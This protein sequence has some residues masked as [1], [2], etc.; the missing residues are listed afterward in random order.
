[1]ATTVLVWVLFHII[2][3]GVLAIDLGL[4]RRESRVV[5]PGEATLWTC[6]WVAISLLICGAIYLAAGPDLALQFLNGYVVEYSL[7]VDNLFVFLLLFQ[8]FGV[9][10]E[11]RHR[12]LFWG[13]AVQFAMRAPL[14]VVGTALASRF[15]WMLYLFG[16]F[17]LYTAWKMAFSGET[18]GFDPDKS[19]VLAWIGRF[20]PLAKNPPPG[21]FFAREGNKLRATQL[22]VVLLFFN[23]TDLMFALDSIPAVI[24]VVNSGNTFIVYSSNVCAIL[25]LRSLFF[26]IASL[27]DK[28]RYL[29]FGVSIILAFVGTKMIISHWIQISNTTSFAIIACVVAVCIAASA[30]IKP[31]ATSSG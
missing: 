28:F 26:V 16:L 11:F 31:P 5:P 13:V 25:G 12:L 7:S 14:I 10:P 1:V 6:L 19:R 9:A 3:F 17:L 23:F 30:V 27:M 22:L 2:V 8:Y 24:G 29:K 4:V 15:S 18:G 21:K 20:M